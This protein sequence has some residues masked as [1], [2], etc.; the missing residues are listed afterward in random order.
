MP[1]KP[2]TKI[3]LLYLLLGICWIFLSDRILY[4][5]VTEEDEHT[6]MVI[7]NIKGTLYVLL[8]GY[9][10]YVLIKSFYRKMEDRLVELEARDKELSALQILTKTGNWEYDIATETISWSPMAAAIFETNL[11]FNKTDNPMLPKFFKNSAGLQ[12]SLQSYD[13][14][15][16]S[17]IPFD[18]ELEIKTA[19][20]NDKC[21][22]VVG[23]PALVNGVAVKI[24]GSCQDITSKK[25]AESKALEALERYDILS[26]C[27][28][29]TIW[30]WDIQQDL[31]L[32][33]QSIEHVFGYEQGQYGITFSW[34]KRNIHKSNRDE[35][36]KIFDEAFATR[37]NT[38]QCNY[39][40]RC[41]DDSFKY[42]ADRANITYNKAGEPVRVIGTMQD[43]TIEMELETRIEKAVINMQEQERQ[44]LGMELHDNVNQILAAA[45]L[46]IGLIKS[47]KDKGHDVN[48]LILKIEQ[49]IK[50]AID[51]LRRLSHDLAPVSFKGVPIE[52][53]IGTLLDS[54]QLQ[55][56]VDVRLFVD[57]KIDG[58]LPLALKLNLYR[59]LQE[60]IGNI[61]KY[62]QATVVLIN[63]SLTDESIIMQIKD[64][65]IGFDPRKK[66]NGIGL[67]NIRRRAKM[68]E[69]VFKLNTAPGMGCEIVVEL[70]LAVS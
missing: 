58:D 57:P 14:A 16:F 23:T 17:G 28:R 25:E 26:Q 8:T 39:R 6:L 55:K 32:Y 67:E 41:A 52:D 31:V 5:F 64:N 37:E 60:Q 22:R 13:D 54:F 12:K 70:S 69:G 53:V 61:I 11:S 35:V 65:G 33:N 4:Q 27:T 42:V 18:F 36:V 46:F 30:D 62:A 59:I 34:R 63:L 2:A 47:G 24:Y 19:K 44:Q 15:R 45:L 38:V 9:L 7:Q 10:L 50:D 1:L 49:Y 21:V 56:L 43:V 29:D 68:F 51:D 48:E 66:S 40:F 3:T 20:G